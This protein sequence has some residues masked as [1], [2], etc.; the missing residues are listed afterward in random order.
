[1]LH[2]DGPARSD[3][4]NVCE[5]VRYRTAVL[6]HPDEADLGVACAGRKLGLSLMEKKHN[7]WEYLELPLGL[8]NRSIPTN[9]L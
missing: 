7:W 6:K 5:N 8:R 4:P 9:S 3:I 2:V 1:V